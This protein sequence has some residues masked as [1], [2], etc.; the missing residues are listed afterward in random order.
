MTPQLHRQSI[1]TR[2]CRRGAFAPARAHCP[3]T[4]MVSVAQSARLGQMHSTEGRRLRCPRVCRSVTGTTLECQNHTAGWNTRAR[5]H[6]IVELALNAGSA[7]TAASTFR[8]PG[9]FHA[10][11]R[12]V[13][14]AAMRATLSHRPLLCFGGHFSDLGTGARE[15]SLDSRKKLPFVAFDD[16]SLVDNTTCRRRRGRN[17]FRG[18][19]D[20]VMPSSAS[21][22]ITARTSP[23]ARDRG[24]GR[25]SK[26]ERRIH[27]QCARIPTRGFCPPD[28]G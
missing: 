26:E 15:R 3:C 4:F 8:A 11:L 6:Q 1:M 28:S 5:V 22:R 19:H 25:S 24:A 21:V 12:N 9:L 16:Q 18:H 14:G 13:P 2:P 23:R 7:A 10:A 20:L 27:C 17:P